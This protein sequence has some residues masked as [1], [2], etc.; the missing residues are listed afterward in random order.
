M[1]TAGI[2]SLSLAMWSHSPQNSSFR[3]NSLSSFL[4]RSLNILWVRLYP[5]PASRRDNNLV[6]GGRYKEF[7]MERRAKVVG[8]LVGWG[9]GGVMAIVHGAHNCIS[10]EYPP[11]PPHPPGLGPLL[12]H[13]R[14]PETGNWLHGW[15]SCDHKSLDIMSHDL[16]SLRMLRTPVWQFWTVSFSGEDTSRAWADNKEY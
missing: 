5:E 12:K 2:V 16:K 11:S 13:V 4:L 9:G 8:W 10:R 7:E 6:G 1:W 3:W 14:Q 15:W